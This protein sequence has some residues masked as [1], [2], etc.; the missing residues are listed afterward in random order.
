MAQPQPARASVAHQVLKHLEFF[1]T[2]GFADFWQHTQ[3]LAVAAGP[4]D[5]KVEPKTPE[6]Q[7]GGE[8]G[9]HRI[10]PQVTF[11]GMVGRHRRR[12]SG[13]RL[14]GYGGRGNDLLHRRCSYRA[15]Q[16]E[17]STRTPVSSPVAWPRAAPAAAVILT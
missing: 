5:G 8:P 16:A 4:F 7:F 13:W 14:L 17:M 9:S 3:Q 11:I 12:I 10:G 6:P 1:G 2:D 15:D